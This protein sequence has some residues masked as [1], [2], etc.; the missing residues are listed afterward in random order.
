M[1]H[2]P[3]ETASESGHSSALDERSISTQLTQISQTDN[4]WGVRELMK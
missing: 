4:L 3:I 1:L 2:R